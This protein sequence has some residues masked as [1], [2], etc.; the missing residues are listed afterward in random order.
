[1]A[2]DTLEDLFLF[3]PPWSDGIRTSTHV[4]S[5]FSSCFVAFSSNSL[6]WLQLS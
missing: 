6:T 4:F 5:A 1:M 2:S 3:F